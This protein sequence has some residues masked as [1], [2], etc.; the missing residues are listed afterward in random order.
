MLRLDFVTLFPDLVRDALAHSMMRRAAEGGHA[1]FKTVNP[2]DYCYDKHQKV[3]DVP[4]GGAAGMLIKAEP[5]A[6]ALEAIGLSAD[7]R[8]P[9]VELIVTDPTGVRF[10]QQL[11][12]ELS[13][14]RRVVFLCGH[15]EG[16]DQRVITH[17]AARPVSIGDFV[18][19]NGELPALIIADALVRLLPG[20]LGSADSLK[21]DSHSDGLLSAPNYT[22]PE[23]WR[24]ESIPEVLK[25]GDHRAIE[26][27]R[28][29]QSLLATRRL[30]P[31]LLAK[32]KVD[33]PDLNVLSS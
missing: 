7:F 1:Q 32:A 28:R 26:R 25:S 18:L 21:A 19:T 5:V 31:D 15:Y 13:A 33:K 23:V 4:F 11:A 3:D 22:R 12:Q 30:R 24:G 16:F 14:K 20:V 29:E 8:E 2:R 9:D 6:L 27:W 17:F 10:D